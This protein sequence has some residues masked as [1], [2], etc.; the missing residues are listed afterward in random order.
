MQINKIMVS[1]KRKTDLANNFCTREQQNERTN[2]IG[3]FTLEGQHSKL[4]WI[5][6]VGRKCLRGKK[7]GTL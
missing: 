6:A 4:E 5:E 2:M 1:T 3:I 7:Q